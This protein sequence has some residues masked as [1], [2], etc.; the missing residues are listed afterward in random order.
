M[1]D[2]VPGLSQVKSLV[3]VTFGDAEG[4]ERTQQNFIRQCP[5][6]SQV[7]SA[8][9][10]GCGDNKAALETQKQFGGAMS[11]LADGIPLVGHIKGGI[12]YACGDDEPRAWDG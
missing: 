12:H 10:A 6:V 11:G 9:Q 7:T 8:V 2:W 3:Q 5:V 4:A 1:V